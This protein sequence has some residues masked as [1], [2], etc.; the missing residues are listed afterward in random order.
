MRIRLLPCRRDKKRLRGTAGGE[1]S[2]DLPESNNEDVRTRERRRTSLDSWV[3]T[4]H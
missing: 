4:V 2:S 1:I 3:D